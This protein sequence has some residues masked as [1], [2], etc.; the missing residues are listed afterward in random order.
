MLFSEKSGDFPEKG[1]RVSV[2]KSKVFNI[3]LIRK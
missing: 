3:I 1:R 2:E